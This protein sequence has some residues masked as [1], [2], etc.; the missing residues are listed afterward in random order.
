MD[1]PQ[2]VEGYFCGFMINYDK[3]SFHRVAAKS[4]DPELSDDGTFLS[5]I[6][7]IFHTIQWSK[8]YFSLSFH[9]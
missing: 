1:R 6:H 5:V 4:P 2:L 9:R 3:P 8:K 7:I